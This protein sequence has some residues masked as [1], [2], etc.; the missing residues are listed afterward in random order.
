MHQT[1]RGP[2]SGYFLRIPHHLLERGKI[3]DVARTARRCNSAD[4]QRAIAVMFLDDLN[5]FSFFQNA[6]MPIQITVRKSAKLFEIAERQTFRIRNQGCQHAEACAFVNHGIKTFL[7]ETPSA[8]QGS[9]FHPWPPS[10][11]RD[12]PPRPPT[13]LLQTAYHRP[14]ETARACPP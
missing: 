4:R 9:S 12:D 6:Q 10:R 2:F 13:A 3:L 1:R 14:R 7:G 8:W 11:Q 5:H